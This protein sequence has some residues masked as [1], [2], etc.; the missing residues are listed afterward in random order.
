[1][2]ARLQAG[3]VSVNEYPITFPQ[4]PFGGYKE[5]GI[6]R[7]QGLEAVY[8]YSRVK[9]V[10]INPLWG[11][12]RWDLRLPNGVFWWRGLTFIEFDQRMR[13]WFFLTLFLAGIFPLSFLFISVLQLGPSGF[14][15]AILASFLLTLLGYLILRRDWS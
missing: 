10:L 12:S 13:L 7:E 6:G 14:L 4:T 15:L 1:M 2:A 3:I 8:H 9:N 5:S 11:R